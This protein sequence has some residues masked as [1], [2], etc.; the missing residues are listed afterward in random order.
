MKKKPSSTVEI[1][2]SVKA[3]NIEGMILCGTTPYHEPQLSVSI[4]RYNTNED[5][6]LDVWRLDIEEVEP[7]ALV[8]NALVKRLRKLEVPTTSSAPSLQPHGRT[9]P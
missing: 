9:T 3:G 4:S 2:R 6:L 7:V 8:L 1:L 5:G